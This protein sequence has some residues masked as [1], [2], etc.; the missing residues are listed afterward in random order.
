MVS[1]IRVHSYPFVI[2]T[3]RVTKLLTKLGLSTGQLSQSKVAQKG[4]L[5]ANLVTAHLRI[6]EDVYGN[7]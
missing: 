6:D 1:A 3:A 5:G 2:Q 4:G 7:A